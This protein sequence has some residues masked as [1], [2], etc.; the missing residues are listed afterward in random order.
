MNAEGAITKKGGNVVV[1]GCTAINAN[2]KKFSPKE[3]PDTVVKLTNKKSF[4]H[5]NPISPIL[6]PGVIFF[7][8]F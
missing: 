6:F 7:P 8:L 4:C 2:R 3:A 5:G 1:S